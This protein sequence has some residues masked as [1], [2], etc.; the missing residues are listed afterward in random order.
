MAADQTLWRLTLTVGLHEGET[1]CEAVLK[2]K[3]LLPQNIGAEVVK[4]GAAI[5]LVYRLQLI[6]PVTPAELVASL[7]RVPVWKP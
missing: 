6:P 4:R 3:T 2:D 7:N 1:A 5:E